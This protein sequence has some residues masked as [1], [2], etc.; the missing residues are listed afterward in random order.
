MSEQSAR[1][2]RLADAVISLLADL[3]EA[4]ETIKRLRNTR[5]PMCARCQS[6]G[7]AAPE[8]R[9]VCCCCGADLPEEP[10]E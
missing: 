6:E 8:I 1:M 3:A 9:C 10:T 5:D 7:C 4:N 2:V